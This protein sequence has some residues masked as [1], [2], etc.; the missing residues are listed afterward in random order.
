MGLLVL[1]TIVPA[2]ESLSL[3]H[4]E[5]VLQNVVSTFYLFDRRLKL[6]GVRH[7]LRIVI[8]VLVLVAWSFVLAAFVTLLARLTESAFISERSKNQ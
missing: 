7:E 5:T 2:R 6:M 4:E 8:N 1:P 3:Q